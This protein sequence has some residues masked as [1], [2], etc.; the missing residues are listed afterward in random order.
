[1]KYFLDKHGKYCKQNR[2]QILQLDRVKEAIG[3]SNPESFLDD[4]GYQQI[5]FAYDDETKAIQNIQEVMNDS[6]DECDFT[7]DPPHE[8]VLLKSYGDLSAFNNI[9]GC[10][11]GLKD[12]PVLSDQRALFESSENVPEYSCGIILS[13]NNS[14]KRD[15]WCGN[16]VLN[17][18]FQAPCYASYCTPFTK[19]DGTVGFKRRLNSVESEVTPNHVVWS[20][21]SKAYNSTQVITTDPGNAFLEPL[22]D[23]RQKS[24]PDSLTVSPERALNQYSEHLNPYLTKRMVSKANS[25]VRGLY[26]LVPSRWNI[27]ASPD[28]SRNGAA[29]LVIDKTDMKL[30]LFVVRRDIHI[31]PF[32]KYYYSIWRLVGAEVLAFNPDLPDFDYE[33]INQFHQSYLNA[34]ITPNHLESPKAMSHKY[35]VTIAGDILNTLE[36]PGLSGFI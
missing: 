13:Y 12:S 8:Y 21:Y 35:G 20:E 5:G 23:L 27:Y 32:K 1:M 24:D 17:E 7:A 18:I 11:F 33:K 25:N 4:L 9:P 2:T 34:E 3:S 31:F 28:E 29:C 30:K 14:S 19:D 36:D 10:P 15:L 6:Y 22:K 16:G 26:S